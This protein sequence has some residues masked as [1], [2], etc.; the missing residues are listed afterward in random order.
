M[1]DSTVLILHEI[2]ENPAVI[3]PSAR[4]ALSTTTSYKDL[5]SLVASFQEVLARMGIGPEDKIAIVL[6]NGLELVVVF[7]AFMRERAIAAPVNPQYKQGEYHEILQLVRP[8]YLVTTSGSRTSSPSVLAA[9]SLAIPLARCSRDDQRLLLEPEAEQAGG[10]GKQGKVLSHS[11][12]QPD[13]KAL[14]LFTSG[15][16][17]AP[18][19]VVLTHK[20]LLIAMRILVDAHH[21]SA[22]DRCMVI[23]PLFHVVGAFWQTCQDLGATW[24]HAVPTLHRLLLSFPR[25]DQMPAIRFMRSGGSDLSPDL[26]QRLNGLGFP[27]LEIYGMTET[28]PGIFCNRL[29]DPARRLAHYPIPLAVEVMIMPTAPGA[30]V[31]TN[32][33]LPASTSET[34]VV[35]EICVRGGSIMSGYIDNPKANAEVFLT[36]GF[37][38]TGDLGV[39]HPNGYLQLTGRIKEI[40]NKGGE[41]ISPTEIEHL[42]LSYEAVRETACFRI[43][44]E[45]HGKEIGL[46]VA[47][48]PGQEVPTA[49]LKA[50]A[51]KHAVLFKVPKVIVVVDTIPTNRTGK[52][53][54]TFPSEQF[55]QGLLVSEKASHT[56]GAGT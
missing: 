8:S 3:I 53:K 22:T 5:N 25:P 31:G 34:G 29:D 14:L 54:R 6:P 30:D 55:A 9:Q 11:D 49:K 24:F 12:V 13:D 10:S 48:Q 40:I 51:R 44:D 47:F 23:T 50:Y 21:S 15:T 2:S 7:L 35:G 41:K 52:P 17:G 43:A 45:M 26:D 36:N 20:N 42:N 19:A 28:S 1:I 38:R 56:D 32:A 16:T 33:D 18:E 46:A 39:L 4:D 37:F 27:L